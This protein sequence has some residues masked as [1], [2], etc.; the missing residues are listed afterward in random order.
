MNADYQAPRTGLF[1]S[2][3]AVAVSVAA[4]CIVVGN[5]VAPAIGLA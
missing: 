1:D 3:F 4:L 2:L 5:V